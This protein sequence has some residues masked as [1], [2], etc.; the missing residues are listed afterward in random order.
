L[1]RTMGSSL[2]KRRGYHGR[3]GGLER[4]TLPCA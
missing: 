4:A 2:K 1:V 3:A